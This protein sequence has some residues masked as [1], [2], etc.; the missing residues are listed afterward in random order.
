M[1]GVFFGVADATVFSPRLPRISPWLHQQKTTATKAVF[2][3][4]PAKTPA[5]QRNRSSIGASIFFLQKQFPLLGF[6]ESFVLVGLLQN[7]ECLFLD[8]LVG[9]KTFAVEV[10]LQPRIDAAGRPEVHQYPG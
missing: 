8:A 5:K 3:N 10:V 4:T 7:K 9:D 6:T 2:P 1:S